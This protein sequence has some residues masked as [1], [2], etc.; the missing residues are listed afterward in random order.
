MN[1]LKDLGRDICSNGFTIV[2]I[3]PHD[4]GKQGAGKRPIGKDWEKTVNSEAR[5]DAWAEKYPTS[6]IGI[7]T[8]NTPAVDIDILDKEASEYMA[9]WVAMNIGLAPCR[10]GKDPKKLFLFQC[11]ETFTKVKSAVWEDDFGADHAVE[12]LADGQQFVA[13]GIHPDTEKE[14]RWVGVDNP[15]NMFARLDLEVITLDQA[16]EIADEFDRYAKE[17]G[18]SMKRRP[19]NGSDAVD[20]ADE[21]DWAANADIRKWE[22]DYITLREIVMKYPNPENYD[23]WITVLSALQL[24]C[25][26]QTEAKEIA[27]D[28]SMQANNYDDDAFEEKWEK[29]F[30]HKAHKL[31]TL[32]SIIK[33]VKDIEKAEVEEK[34]VEFKEGFESCTTMADWNDWADSLRKVKVFGHD[35]RVIVEIASKKYQQINGSVLNRDSKKELLGYDV[36]SGTKPHWLRDFVFSE[37]ND[38]IV[39]RKTNDHILKG[40]FD[41]AYQKYCIVG[42]TKF[43][44]TVFASEVY[45][46]PVVHDCMYYPAMHGDMPDTMW[47][48]QD[49]LLGPEFFYDAEGRMWLNSFRP[50]TLPE[51]ATKL[52]KLDKKAIN[53]IKDFLIVLFPSDKERGYVMD[54]LAWIIQNPTKRIN[55]SLLV[56]GAHGSG[57][58]SLG[59]MMEVMLGSPNVDYVSNTV[60]NGRFS[61]WA[62][63]HILKI[64]EEVYDKSDRFSAVERQKEFISNDSFQVEPKGFKARRVINTS[65]KLM[66][67]NHFNALPLDKN[68]RRYLVVSTQAENY[69]DM[70]SVYGDTGERDAFFR[71][72]HQALD[73]HGPA[74]KRFFMEWQVSDTFN[75][76]G[77]APQDTDAFDIMS[78]AANDG[79]SASIAQMMEDGNTVGVNKDII[80]SPSLRDAIIGISDGEMPKTTRLKNILMELGFRPGGVLKFGGEPGRVYV[81]KKIRGAFS[82]SGNLNTKWAQETLK[83]H[84]D[85][86]KDKSGIPDQDPD[87]W[88]GNIDDI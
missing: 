53:I 59:K 37:K 51:A 88:R 34:Q 81:R 82:E 68:Q 15:T 45:P 27:R 47:R 62:E 28:W 72:V 23:S 74:I 56:R 65:S 29:G 12:I 77:H 3:Y 4:S 84:N 61:D 43:K 8:K 10:I 14:Y 44:P 83:K 73:N 54:W 32:G 19:I 9:N 85:N 16:R 2:P 5:V 80:F 6:G 50:E 78:D 30:S 75:H 25:N 46:V 7:L 58:S 48:M 76:K 55:Y 11:E 36:S 86:I 22:G 57:K 20:V 60:M 52:S 31:V 66:F 41:F 42:D 67:T 64:V 63:G 71:N 18:W 40:A 87:D 13:F 39:R 24:S 70:A 21:D 33:V 35:R 38:C 49:G 26:D 1:Y 17:R 79:L 69:L